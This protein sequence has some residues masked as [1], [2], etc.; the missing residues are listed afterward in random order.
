MSQ[1]TFDGIVLLLS[2]IVIAMLTVAGIKYFTSTPAAKNP[3]RYMDPKTVS[4]P[5]PSLLPPKDNAKGVVIPFVVKGDKVEI[6]TL[7]AT[8]SVVMDQAFSEASVNQ[9]MTEI[10][11]LSRKASPSA[12][13]YL[14]LNSPGGSVDA[15]LKLISFIKALPQKVSTLTIFSASMAFQ[16]VQQLDERLLLENGTLMSHRARFGVSGE[17]PGELFSRLKWIMSMVDGLDQAAAKRMGMSFDDYRNLIRDEY[18]VY[19]D[20]AVRDNAV[21]RKVLARCDESLSG[22]KRIMVETFFGTFPVQVSKCPLIPGVVSVG[23]PDGGGDVARTRQ[24]QI[25]CGSNAEFSE[26]VCHGLYFDE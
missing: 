24:S 23:S 7:S 1:K 20:H 11:T 17:G 13:L 18:W 2:M 6:I 5:L 25:V 19:D 16:T 15:G 12:T 14:V 4:T 21:D 26:S 8:N 10:Q 3:F 22:T 9:V